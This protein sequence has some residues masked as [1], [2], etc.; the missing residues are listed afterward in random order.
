VT[1]IQKSISLSEGTWIKIEKMRKNLPRS[2]FV[3]DILA[4]GL[5]QL[6]QNQ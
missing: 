6:E 3:A 1:Q 4:G 5:K 2:R